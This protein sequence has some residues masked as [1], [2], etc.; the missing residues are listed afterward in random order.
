MRLTSLNQLIRDRQTLEGI[1]TLAPNHRIQYRRRRQGGEEEIVL[2]AEPVSPK[3]TG[4]VI[5]IREESSDGEVAHRLLTLRGRWQADP[6]NRLTFLVERERGRHDELRFTGGWEI[7]DHHEIVYR[8]PSGFL[9]FQ[10]YWDIA[11]DKRLTYL[12]DKASDSAFRFRGSFQTDSLL[13]KEGALRYQVG[14]ELEGK[15]EVKTVTLF[16]KWKLSRGLG[17]QLEIPYRDGFKRSIRFEASYTTIDAKRSIVA[18]LSTRAG[19]PLGVE[20]LFTQAFFKADG[21]AFL[22]LK[23]SMEENRL[24]GGLRVRW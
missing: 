10:G 17:L 19:E 20:L 8:Y 11:E 6:H 3:A 18:R 21:E 22:R 5:G 12:L 14:V 15:T 2:T 4:L 13:A 9:T 7:D 16:G 1:W 24:E 23:K